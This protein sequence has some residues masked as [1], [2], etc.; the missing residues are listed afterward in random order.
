[1]QAADDV[2]WMTLFRSVRASDD[3]EK[4]GICWDVDGDEALESGTNTFRYWI[5][6]GDGGWEDARMPRLAMALNMPF[7]TTRQDRRNASLPPESWNVVIEPGEI[8]MSALMP[9]ADA[10]ECL[11]RLFN[12]GERDVRGTVRVRDGE[13]QTVDFAPY[14]IKNVM[15]RPSGD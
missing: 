10:G 9:T 3:R 8:V 11:M 4:G 5:R 12:P 14:E 2:L 15:L 1:M 6:P 13:T 7:P